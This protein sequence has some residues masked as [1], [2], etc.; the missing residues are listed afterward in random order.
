MAYE[1]TN[2][3]GQKYYLHTTTVQLRGGNRTQVIY[4]FAREVGDKALDEIPEGF[5]V[6]ENS[7]TGLPILKKISK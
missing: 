2:A 3:K 5:E 4:Y 6:K 1:Y 7:R